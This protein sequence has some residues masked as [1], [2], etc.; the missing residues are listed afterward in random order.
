MN[1]EQMAAWMEVGSPAS[2]HEYL[3]KLEGTWKAKLKFWMAPNTEPQESEGTSTNKLILGDRFL[4]GN[5]EGQTPWGAF[6]GMSIDGYDR[7]RNKYTG[8]WM[9]SMGT[10]MMVFE[11]SVDGNV[12]TMMCDFVDPSGKPSQ[13]KGVTTIVSENE[14]K[15]E[16]W[17][18]TPDGDTFQ[19]MEILYTR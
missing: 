5:Y 14:H 1:E 15:Y 16:S 19:N 8:L 6:S 2:E 13:M 7:I 11:G 18:Q 12:R 4:Q 17:A 10:I 3:K 9:D